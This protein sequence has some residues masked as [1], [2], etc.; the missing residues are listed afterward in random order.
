MSS[1]QNLVNMSKNHLSQLRETS[2]IDLLYMKFFIFILQLNFKSLDSFTGITSIELVQLNFFTSFPLHLL[3]LTKTNNLDWLAD[4]S[5]TSPACSTDFTLLPNFFVIHA[6][7]KI[8]FYCETI[9]CVK[10]RSSFLSHTHEKQRIFN[11]FMN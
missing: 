7:K 4:M 9:W 8:L 3:S 2:F 5:L 1:S 6:M 11:S 10:T